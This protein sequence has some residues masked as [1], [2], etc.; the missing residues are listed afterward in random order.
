MRI[1]KAVSWQKA[2]LHQVNTLFVWRLGVS[3]AIHHQLHCIRPMP[4]SLHTSVQCCSEQGLQC[5][6]QSLAKR[7]RLFTVVS[8]P[9][10]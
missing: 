4:K 6:L 1:K 7:P 8:T 2:H 9:A 10:G 5:C 3:K